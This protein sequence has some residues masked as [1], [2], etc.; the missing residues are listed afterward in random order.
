MFVYFP[1]YWVLLRYFKKRKY[2]RVENFVN[3]VD[4]KFFS[5]INDEANT[6][7]VKIS[8]SA[9]YTL[10]YL[11]IFNYKNSDLK[12][13]FLMCPYILLLSGEGNYIRPFYLCESDPF[14]SC[15]YFAINK[16]KVMEDERFKIMENLV[17]HKKRMENSAQM[18]S[19]LGKFNRL[20]RAIDYGSSKEEF[21][22]SLMKI[23]KFVK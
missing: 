7:R 17:A 6:I 4:I 12:Y 19:F 16:S 18:N 2:R 11:D 13:F 23:V 14:L 5:H 9:D 20:A 8:K 22:K 15:L 3:C 10:L 21:I 1:I